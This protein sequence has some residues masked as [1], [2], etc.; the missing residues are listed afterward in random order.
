MATVV[1]TM[2]HR[3]VHCYDPTGEFCAL[4]VCP[5]PTVARFRY[6]GSSAGPVLRFHPSIMS[7]GSKTG[8]FDKPRGN[9]TP[10]PT[11]PKINQTGDK[12]AMCSHLR[13][14][15][16]T[17]DLP[18]GLDLD[19]VGLSEEYCLSRTPVRDVLRLLAG[20]G[21]VDIVG[22]RGARVSP[23]DH[24]T[25]R[26]F[27]Q[28]APMIYAS[29][30]RLAVENAT[31]STVAELKRVQAKFRKAA[32]KQLIDELVYF[33]NEFHAL[34]G[35]MADNRYLDASLRRLLIDHSRI[36]Y[37]FYE[38]K[39]A[40]EG[41]RLKLAIEQHDQ[42]IE[43]IDTGDS[44]AAVDVTLAH[45]ELSRSRAEIYIRPQPL[46]DESLAG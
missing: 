30:S 29:V 44:E 41:N 13:R 22:N 16:L 43:A 42:L 20:E 4:Q 1:Y 23:M 34:I 12:Q 11:R 18:P 45:W 46:A 17:L 40:N 38:R 5:A 19:E 37:T 24:K 36:A 8:Y 7:K 28:T 15:I 39:N 9:L 25:I 21:F 27:F 26:E 6:T 2:Y 31:A 33:N 10:M 35:S 3:N 32:Q 14:R